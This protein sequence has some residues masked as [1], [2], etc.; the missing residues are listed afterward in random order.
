MASITCEILITNKFKDTK[1][2]LFQEVPVI[3]GGPS[4]DVFSNV[5]KVTDSVEAAADGSSTL[6]FY[7]DNDFYAI[8]GSKS[9]SGSG[10]RINTSSF[11]KI[12][13]GPGG[14]VLAVSNKTNTF[15]WDD[16]AVVGRSADS[17]GGFQLITDDTIPTDNGESLA[18]ADNSLSPSQDSNRPDVG[19]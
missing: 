14:T 5:F 11:R 6:S 9:G 16:A 17:R 7:L 13:L 12:N 15:K 18:L 4:S 19:R 2:F 8:F 10:T 3:E 1:F